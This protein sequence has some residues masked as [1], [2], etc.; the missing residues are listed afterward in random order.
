MMSTKFQIDGVNVISNFEMAEREAQNY[1]DFVRS[2][3]QTPLVEVEVRLCNDGK[4]DLKYLARGAR[5]ERLRRITGYLTSDL[6]FWNDAKRAEE[7]ERVK[8]G[9]SKNYGYL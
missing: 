2:K 1:V 5:F 4:V 6:K 8:H 3:I 9:V 7:S